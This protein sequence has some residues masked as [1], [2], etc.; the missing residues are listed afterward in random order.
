MR[1]IEILYV[2]KSIHHIVT[3]LFKSVFFFSDYV[4]TFCNP[5]GQGESWFLKSYIHF[6]YMLLQ[7]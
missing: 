5:W 7:N 2:D 6:K 1:R 3:L 4:V